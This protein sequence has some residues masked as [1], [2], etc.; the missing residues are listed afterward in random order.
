MGNERAPG[1]PLVDLGILLGYWVYAGQKSKTLKF[2]S[3]TNQA[4]WFERTKIIER[5]Q[6][7]T[8]FNLD[9]LRYFEVF[10]NFKNAVVAQQ[11]FYRYKNGQTDDAR[12]ADFDRAVTE[13]ARLAA[14]LI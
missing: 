5:Y 10:A 2:S 13:L 7:R 12:F 1:D 11:I 3:V 14:E 9:N 6:T 8:N 4:G